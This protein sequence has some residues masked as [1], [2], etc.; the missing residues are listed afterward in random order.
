MYFNSAQS[1]GYVS[2]KSQKRAQ[3]VADKATNWKAD[4]PAE[5]DWMEQATKKNENTNFRF[6]EN[7]VAALHNYGGLTGGQLA[8]VRKCMQRDAAYDA[9]KAAGKP[10]GVAVSVLKIEEAF[11]KAKAKAN[12]PGQLGVWLRL[13][14]QSGG[15]T[16][17]FSL[18][19]DHLA[20][21][22]FVKEGEKRLGT[23]EG[24]NF[25]PRFECSAAEQTAVLDVCNDPL[26]AAKAYGKAWSRCCVCNRELTNDDSIERMMGPICA[27]KFGW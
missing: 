14:M 6:P 1:S 17:R 25:T 26:K 16:L 22:I 21:K 7:M 9:K 19:R 10:E 5:W 27:E 18:G 11:A 4:N 3:A 13:H 20:G 8:A 15:H 2:S 23:I 12:R 24:G